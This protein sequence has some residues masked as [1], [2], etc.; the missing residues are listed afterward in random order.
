[1]KACFRCRTELT[2][3]N[4]SAG[5]L[6]VASSNAY[7]RECVRIKR[8][9]EIARAEARG[10]HPLSR[11]EVWLPKN[12]PNRLTLTPEDVFGQRRAGPANSEHMFGGRTKS[13]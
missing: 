7:C 9:E 3:E 11:P 13:R 5:A 6:R 4:A 1:M 8:S 10:V 12:H 2:P